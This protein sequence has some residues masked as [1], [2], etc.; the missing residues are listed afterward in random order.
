MPRDYGCQN[1]DDRQTG[2]L[3]NQNGIALVTGLVLMLILTL[4]SYTAIKWAASDIARSAN[5]AETIQATYIAEAGIHKAIDYLNYDASGDSPGEVSNGFDDELD[6]TNWP[7]GTFTSIG[8]GSDG[9]TYSIVIEDNTDGDGSTVLDVDNSVV[10][11]STGTIA[12]LSVIIET[13]IYRPLFK[14]Q[15]A[16]L[17]EGDVGVNGNS[18]SI[19]G[20][21]GAVHTNSDFTQ[22]GTPT[23]NG[24][25]NASGTCTGAECNSAG[26]VSEEFVPVLEPS[27]YEQ[28]A[29]YIFN[30][31]GTIDQKNADGTTT[32]GVEGNALFSGFSHNNQGWR[33]SNSA[34]AGT[35]IPNQAFL[36][37]KDDLTATSVG[38]AATPW[39]ITLVVEKTISFGNADV[40][41]W[42][43][44]D[45]SPDL[46]NLF[47][48]AE[49][50]IK[51]TGMNQNTQGLI[52][53]KD[54]ISLSGGAS[55]EGYLISNNL[56]T[57]DNTVNGTDTIVGGG[58][59]LTYNGDLVA[60][61]LSDKVSILTWQKT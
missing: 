6:G 22:A 17:S 13:V 49:N 37:F 7:A 29:D 24:G 14:S 21:N 52:A 44:P 1:R 28:N 3:S 54:Q 31:D 19:T 56:T 12:G 5:Y 41:N 25:A 38:S 35:D 42:K 36:Y 30:D 51:I 34:V 39:E 50:D 45:I 58:I 27:D 46:Q 32:T 11:K 47:L 57:S 48:V 40:I 60:P 55:I 59:T 8:I 26:G 2:H 33:V 16:I 15:Y 53:A 43:D 23:I 61:V 10:L 4:L 18:T 20:T 9:G